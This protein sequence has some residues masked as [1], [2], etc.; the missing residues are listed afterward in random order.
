MIEI[1]WTIVGSLASGT[2]AYG[3]LFLATEA[4]TGWTSDP[5]VLLIAVLI[6]ALLCVAGALIGS[7]IAGRTRNS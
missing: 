5:N 3:S 2:I 6:M 1:K 4:A 7:I